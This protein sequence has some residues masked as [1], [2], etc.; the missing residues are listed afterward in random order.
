MGLDITIIQNGTPIEFVELNPDEHWKIITD[1]KKN[2]LN[3]IL[4]MEDYYSD[5]EYASNEITVLLDEYKLIKS[6]C[7]DISY[8]LTINKIITILQKAKYNNCDIFVISD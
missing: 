3:L 1:G 6:H 4:R 7:I 5:V 2:N 8:E